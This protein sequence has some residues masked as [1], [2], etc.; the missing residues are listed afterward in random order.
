MDFLKFSLFLLS[1]ALF[2]CQDRKEENF[3]SAEKEFIDYKIEKEL[4]P[5]LQE[6]IIAEIT[7]NEIILDIPELSDKKNLIATFHFKGKVVFANSEEQESGISAND[8]TSELEYTIEAE[9]GSVKTY[10]LEV[11]WKDNLRSALAHIYININDNQNIS[12]KTEYVNGNIRIDGKGEY[13]DY[14]GSIKIRGRGN[15]SWYFPK[16]PYK[17]K[18]DSKAS[19][20]GMHPYKEWILLSEYLDGTMLYNSIPYKAGR[21]LEI[22]YTNHVFPVE[23]T[24][25]NKY[26]GIYALTEHKEVGENRIDIGN[27][28]LLLELDSYYDEEWKFK[29][30]KYNLPVMIQFPKEK[31]MTEDKLSEIKNDFEIFEALIS[32]PSFPENNYLEYFDDHSFINYLIVYQLTLNQEINHPKSTYIN[33]LAE[34]KY[35]MGI[36]WDFDWGFGYEEVSRHYDLSTAT[37]PLILNSS[38]PGSIFFGRLM[39]DPHLQALFKERWIWFR[40]NKYQELRD[41]V[42]N[43]S[44]LIQDVISKDHAIWGKR[45]SSGDAAKDLRKVLNWMDARAD[46]LDNYIS[47]F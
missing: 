45:G 11:R 40:N 28:G 15:S 31:N 34:G 8:Y 13:D 35:S 33:R 7:G 25:N 23:L 22:P 16:K 10:I 47:G 12:S 5:G 19:L 41:Y 43:W 39:K 32:D 6:T 24:I 46:Y 4:N 20:L 2:S 29:S 42:I 26:Q 3:L 17:L 14:T 30:S 1:L 9:D 27:D 18:L 44:G 38:R 36:I 37:S 21:L